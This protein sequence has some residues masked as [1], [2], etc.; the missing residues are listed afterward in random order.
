MSMQKSN[1]VKNESDFSRA[2]I[3]KIFPRKSDSSKPIISCFSL[4]LRT[5][6]SRDRT[7]VQ[8]YTVNLIFVFVTCYSLNCHEFLGKLPNKFRT[9]V[10]RCCKQ[11]QKQE[12]WTH[13][14]QKNYCRIFKEKNDFDSFSA[15]LV[16]CT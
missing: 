15:F 10:A 3:P 7:A 8:W 16:S 2:S 1:T 13:L 14:L 6:H 5:T 11:W 9:A 4:I 12:K